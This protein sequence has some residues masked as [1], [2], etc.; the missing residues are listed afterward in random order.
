MHDIG[1]RKQLLQALD[2]LHG[3]GMRQRRNLFIGLALLRLGIPKKILPAV[4]FVH[5][6]MAIA[7]P[8]LCVACSSTCF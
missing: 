3:P 2:V 1:L 4:L 5:P 6:E 7:L 8:F